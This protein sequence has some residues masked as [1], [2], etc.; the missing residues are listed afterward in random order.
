MADIALTAAQVALCFPLHAEVYPG[1]AAETITAGQAVYLTS[2]GTYGV[3]DANA[4]GKE[5]VRGIALE[6]AVAGKAFSVCKRGHL[7]GFTVSGMAY[8]ALAYLSD[9]AGALGT[10]VSAT[11]TVNVGRVTALTDSSKTKVL[12]VDAVWTAANW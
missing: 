12:Y 3:A 7:Y 2:S 6:D 11:K 5:Q 9:T 1:I 4:A 10:T 8:D